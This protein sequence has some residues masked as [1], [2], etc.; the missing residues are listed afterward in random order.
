MT[1]TQIRIIGIGNPLMGDDGLGIAAIAHLQQK[2]LPPGI[3]L[4]DGGCG[5]LS[6]LA[7]LAECRQAIIID[8]ADFGAT[9][10]SI[11][12]LTAADLDQLPPQTFRP[13]GHQHGLAEVL[14]LLIKLEQLPRLSLIFMQVENCQ[15]RGGLTA[16][17]N[18][19]I[20]N[21]L[22]TVQRCLTA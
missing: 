15:L 22:E 18:A 7:L 4:I 11:K 9:P 14:H 2:P 12:I 1:K 16:R 5:G 19:A 20:P 8:A 10:G 13:T 21:L 17:V 6:L 3:E